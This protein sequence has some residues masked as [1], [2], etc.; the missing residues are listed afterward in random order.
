MVGD[1]RDALLSSRE[2][3]G[4][5]LLLA[6]AGVLGSA[7]L[8][9]CGGTQ[10]AAPAG[11]QAVTAVDAGFDAT[12][13]QLD[14]SFADPCQAAGAFT[15][16]PFAAFDDTPSGV[17]GDL[18]GTYAA[19]IS[20]DLSGALYECV[21]PIAPVVEGIVVPDAGQCMTGY[22]GSA[23]GNGTVGEQ[24]PLSHCGSQ[25][26]GLH[27]R[28]T[29]LTGWGMNV[30]IDLRQNCNGVSTAAAADAG[31]THPCFFDATGWKGVS[32]WARLGFADS[33]GSGA[34]SGQPATT[35]L[36]TVA[37][38]STANELGGSAGATIGSYPFNGPS[39][40]GPPVCGSYPCIVGDPNADLDAGVLPCDPFGKGV[41][42]PTS[43]DG[44]PDPWQFYAIPFSDLRQKG[45]GAP[46]PALDLGHIVNVT[47]N[48]SKGQLGTADDDVWIDDIAFY[49]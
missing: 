10:G 24:M 46:E 25:G 35:L 12:L 39:D 13:G 28:A 21:Q 45:Y 33:P 1:R 34:L 31:G 2:L 16:Q 38:T 5:R 30:G 29:G 19:Y 37:D 15:Y 11:S 26:Y 49:K 14:P 47:I 17:L 27:L 40:G 43:G 9:A 36:V 3:L 7:V 32:F 48:L 20:Y 18:A 42:L 44:G 22:Q 41:L 8:T 6:T 23:G 4:G